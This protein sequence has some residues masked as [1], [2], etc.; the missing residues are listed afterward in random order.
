MRRSVLLVL[1]LAMAAVAWAQDD[2]NSLKSAFRVAR[3]EDLLGR[4]ANFRDT[5]PD[6]SS[7]ELDYMIGAT[8]AAI[9]RF[10]TTACDYFKSIAF[11]YQP[12]RLFDNREVR[13][14]VLENR[15]CP[16]PPPAQPG[17]QET[18]QLRIPNKAALLK[19]VRADLNTSPSP[20][21]T[22]PAE[23]DGTYSMV[24]DGWKGELVL[25]GA[26]GAY[27]ASDGHRFLVRVI[28]PPG[29][30][31]VFI[32]IGLGGENADGLGGQK[33]DGYLMT[34]TR[35][36]IAGLTWWQNQPF[37]FYAIKR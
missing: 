19:K 6:N 32:V 35:D 24:H 1:A 20:R 25:R 16:P 7:F 3:N 37:G 17:V 26:R 18:F 34:Q 2:L 33:F 5:I 27:I 29:Y 8:L 22:S 30:H 36:A 11:T 28:S 31:I 21:P 23:T 9:P 12:P 4:L 14:D 13:L 15:V 10:Q